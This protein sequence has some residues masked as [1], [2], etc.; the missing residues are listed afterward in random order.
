MSKHQEWKM[1]HLLHRCSHTSS[2]GTR[3]VLT[4]AELRSAGVHCEMDTWIA[5]KDTGLVN[6][7]GGEWEANKIRVS[8][9]RA[10]H[11]C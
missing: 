6:W 1:M 9:P 4:E 3:K 2:D 10:F 7:L 5:L 8:V 11:H